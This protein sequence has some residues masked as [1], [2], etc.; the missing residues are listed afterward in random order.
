MSSKELEAKLKLKAN[1]D[2]ADY[3]WES[4]ASKEEVDNSI[5]GRIVLITLNGLICSGKRDAK[6]TRP[7]PSS[8]HRVSQE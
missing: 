4:K 5:K 7:C 8:V 2:D 1:K 3:L 6:A